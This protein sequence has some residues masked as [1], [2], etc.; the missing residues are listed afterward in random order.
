MTERGELV[1]R[2]ATAILHRRAQ[3]DYHAVDDH[4]AWVVDHD[5]ELARAAIAGCESATEVLVKTARAAFVC[6]GFLL[7]TAISGLLLSPNPDVRDN[8]ILW[9]FL[10]SGSAGVLIAEMIMGAKP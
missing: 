7:A 10:V 5:K 9:L 3:E 8:I 1:E 2:V 6:G 4:G